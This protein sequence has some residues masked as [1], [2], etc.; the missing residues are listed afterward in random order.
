MTTSGPSGRLC[1][2]RS[3]SHSPSP[4]LLLEAASQ[5]SLLGGLDAHPAAKS[6]RR[7]AGVVWGGETFGSWGPVVPPGPQE[8]GRRA[9][10]PVRRPPHQHQERR[11][12]W[13]VRVCES[14]TLSPGP[15][16]GGRLAGEGPTLGPAV[17]RG[18]TPARP[19]G[20][21]AALP[22]CVPRM[23]GPPSQR[24]GLSRQDLCPQQRPWVSSSGQGNGQRWWSAGPRGRGVRAALRFSG[25]LHGG[26]QTCGPG[27]LCPRPPAPHPPLLPPSCPTCPAF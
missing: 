5:H 14:L 6:P 7:G 11:G 23:R 8:G 10:E 22:L 12:S 25:L 16:G 2:S 19:Q 3:A 4:S 1:F 21:G 9:G 18:H 13:G 27:R 17:L 20:K 15:Q 26:D 24:P